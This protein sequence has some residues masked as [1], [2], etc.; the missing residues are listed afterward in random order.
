[1]QEVRFSQVLWD[2]ICT[3]VYN[4]YGK[5]TLSRPTKRSLNIVELKA[6]VEEFVKSNVTLLCEVQPSKGVE[7]HKKITEANSIFCFH[8][9]LDTAEQKTNITTV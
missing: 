3:E 7:C 9:S 2:K 5:E 6:D 4:I 8:N 1:M